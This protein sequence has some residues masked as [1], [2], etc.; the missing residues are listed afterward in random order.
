MNNSNGRRAFLKSATLGGLAILAQAPAQAKQ[1]ITAD[2]K[3][4][5]IIGLDTSHS[6]AF[7]ELLNDP[8]AAEDLRG[9]SVVA[10]YPYGSRDIEVSVNMIA[11]NTEKI[12]ALGVEV[13][14]SIQELLSR[15]DFVLLE[16]ND[17]RVHLE[18]A[19]EVFKAGKPVFIDKPVAASLADAVSIFEAAKH[20][21]VPVFT[22]SSLRFMESAQEVVRGKVGKVNGADVYSPARLEKTH[23][24]LFWYGVHGVET[25]FTIMGTGCERVTRT[26]NN[27]FDIV[28]GTWK[29]DRF[30]TF[31]GLRRGKNGYGGT[32]F[33]DEGIAVIGP[34]SG[35]RSLVVEIAKFFRTGI[36]P[37][38][39]EETLEIFAF[40]EAADESKRGGGKRIELADVMRAASREA[41]KFR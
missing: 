23:P 24:D 19:L 3:R 22:S 16:S 26:T 36:A 9:F 37:V 32:A 8:N 29:G 30:G 1:S 11:P 28:V 20:Y 38:S 18:Q 33:G 41:M 14:D 25:L 6:V 4:I 5:G 34:F 13:V 7:T 12:K 35:Y 40:M 31:R 21:G 10:A 2:V 17:G 15:V 39:P 27:D